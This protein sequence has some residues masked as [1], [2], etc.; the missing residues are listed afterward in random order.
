[1][2]GGA[3]WAIVHEVAKSD[4]ISLTFGVYESNKFLLLL[5][6][7]FYMCKFLFLAESQTRPKRLSSN[8]SSSSSSSL[9]VS[10]RLMNLKL[11][12]LFFIASVGMIYNLYVLGES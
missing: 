9:M 6:T 10:K 1:M 2:D 11:T 8:S 12:W 7:A 3:W 4:F 5:Y